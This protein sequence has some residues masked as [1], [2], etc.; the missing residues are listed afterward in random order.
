MHNYL[1]IAR[2][3]ALIDKRCNAHICVYKVTPIDIVIQ[4]MREDVDKTIFEKN[5]K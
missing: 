3:N 1:F 4:F 2:Y 5:F